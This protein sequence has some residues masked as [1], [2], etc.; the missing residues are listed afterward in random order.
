MAFKN[1]YVPEWAYEKY[2]M[3]PV[4]AAHNQP[5]GRDR[6]IWFEYWTVDYEKEAFLV[7]IH[8]HRDDDKEGY[9]FYWKGEWMFFDTRVAD[10][11]SDKVRHAIWFRLL[12]KG[13]VVPDRISAQREAVIADLK[14]ALT[15][16]ATPTNTIKDRFATIEFVGEQWV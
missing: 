10:V 16:R 13:F 2:N 5:L 1:E 7:L 12:V 6:H 4:C 3:K 9:A 11:V 14:E 8:R 15:I